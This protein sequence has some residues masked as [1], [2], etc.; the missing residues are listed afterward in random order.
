MDKDG[1]PVI[2]LVRISDDKSSHDYY[3]ARWTGS[4]WHKTFLTNAGGHFHQSPDIEKCYSGGLAIDDQNPNEV[5]CSVPVEGKHGKVY[6]LIKYIVDD[7]GN[8]SRTDTLTKDSEFN[9]VRPF[10]VPNRRKTPLKLTW[11]YGNY[12]DWIVSRER[13][14]GF[15][16]S[17][18]TDFNL[19]GEKVDLDAGVTHYEADPVHGTEHRSFYLPEATEFSVF[20]DLDLDSATYS[21]EL[22]SWEKLGYGIEK[23]SMKTYVRFDGKIYRSSNLLGTS[24]SWM[25]NAR[26]TN[27]RWCAPV[28]YPSVLLTLVYADGVLSVYV[29]GLL[30]QVVPLSDFHEVQFE[31]G[32]LASKIKLCRIYNR[33]LN[34]TEISRLSG[35]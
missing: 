28:K 27:G 29:N 24:D 18:Y 11:M 15:N 26:S 5:Y 13:P 32:K 25:E 6:E 22:L 17:I 4:E 20:L 2:A 19:K 14:L 30:D 16:T 8:V 3:Y 10:I 1:K 31:V 23:G 35:N 9:N 21:G 33:K 34:F 12:Y 7:S